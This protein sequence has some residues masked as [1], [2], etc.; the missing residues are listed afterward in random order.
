[1]LRV[2]DILISV[3]IVASGIFALVAPPESFL[4]AVDLYWLVY[5]WGALLTL[6]GLLSGIGRT[7]GLW[8]FETTGLALAIPGTA[9]YLGAILFFVPADIGLITAAAL[10]G[11]AML[12]QIRRYVEIQMFI[13]EPGE[14]TWIGRLRA[15]FGGIARNRSK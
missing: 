13:T 5:T 11:V 3:C 6:G 9:I 8:L 12:S 10:F 7:S 15:F 2:L 1:M 4:R 14:D